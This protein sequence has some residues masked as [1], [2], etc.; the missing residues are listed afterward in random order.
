MRVVK[1][2]RTG[3][4]IPFC[5]ITHCPI[6]GTKLEKREEEVAYYCPNPHCDA[7]NIEGL[8]HF[9]SRDTM[10]I[11]G[12]GESIVEDFYNMGYLKSIPDFY[13]LY[14]HKQDLKELERFWGKKYSKFIRFY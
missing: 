4:E 6:C 11:D 3:E 10:N 12:F 1:E 7:R 5:M 9:S 13:K 2:R 14:Q 8:I